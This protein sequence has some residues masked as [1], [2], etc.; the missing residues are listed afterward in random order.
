VTTLRAELDE[1]QF[2]LTLQFE[3]A[4]DRVHGDAVRLQQVFWNILKN[5]IKFTAEKGRITIQTRLIDELDRLS[6][7]FIDTGVGLDPSQIERIF[8]AFVQGDHTS[9]AGGMGLGLAICRALVA[10]HSGSI[11]A[12]SP[13]PGLGTTFIVELPVRIELESTTSAGSNELC[14]VSLQGIPTTISSRPL[15]ILLVED[16]VRSL[17]ALAR[18]LGHQYSVKTAE[19]VA[20]ARHLAQ[21]GRIDLLICD[22]GLPDGSGFE[23][24]TEMRDIYG[25]CGIALTGYGM[26]QDI[27]RS[28]S[29]GFIA[30]LVKPVP[31]ERLKKAIAMATNAVRNK[32]KGTTPD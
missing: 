27:E 18:L 12:Q 22:I 15:V 11:R 10:L 20:Q 19:T 32:T 21:E 16:D 17:E 3:A 14:Q 1:K 7:H 13:G 24:M 4:E 30:H 9:R 25:M 26:D 2:T 29:A 6:I 5:A 8:D 31:V 28:R 23:L